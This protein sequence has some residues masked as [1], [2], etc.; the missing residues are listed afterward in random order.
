MTRQPSPK[1]AELS[2]DTSSSRDESPV[3]IFSRQPLPGA[4]QGFTLDT[5]Q[6]YPHQTAEAGSMNEGVHAMPYVAGVNYPQVIFHLLK[7]ST[8][9]FIK[10]SRPF[11]FSSLISHHL[12]T[13]IRFD[14]WF[15]PHV[16]QP[17]SQIFLP[18]YHQYRN[19]VMMPGAVQQVTRFP[20]AAVQPS[21]F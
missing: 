3:N 13:P 21:H 19:Q 1:Q 7:T 9:H 8:D 15:L 2:S 20:S 17:Q 12:V 18:L 14:Q 10:H 5:V 4:E 11:L 16:L 6:Q